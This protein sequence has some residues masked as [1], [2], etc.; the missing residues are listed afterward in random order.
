MCSGALW[1]FQQ[2]HKEFLFFPSRRP[3]SSQKN[4]QCSRLARNANA[5][6]KWFLFSEMGLF[7][8]EGTFKRILEIK[9]LLK[10]KEKSRFAFK[11]FKRQNWAVEDT[12]ITAL[13][14]A[15][16]NTSPRCSRFSCLHREREAQLINNVLRVNLLHMALTVGPNGVSTLTWDY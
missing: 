13:T 10:G 8:F 3:H 12:A 11:H 2:Q 6:L 16:T 4:S 9:G 1:P 7:L 14:A 5:L 15:A